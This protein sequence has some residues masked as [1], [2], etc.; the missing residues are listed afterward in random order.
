MEEEERQKEK[1]REKEERER[2]EKE[3][4]QKQEEMRSKKKREEEEELERLLMEVGDLEAGDPPVVDME[5][6]QAR[7]AAEGQ[8][9]DSSYKTR[10]NAES[11]QVRQ[12]AKV[13]CSQNGFADG[14]SISFGTL[15][16]DLGGPMDILAQEQGIVMM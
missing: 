7:K 6:S 1:Q 5:A 15:Y 12:V 9:W 8:S 3:L 11:F 13:V 4:R 16:A 14:A 2:A 10:V